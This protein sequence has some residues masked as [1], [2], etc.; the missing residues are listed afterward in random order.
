MPSPER[1]L[2]NGAAAR[3]P[4]GRPRRL[5]SVLPA[6]AHRSKG[7]GFKDW[8]LLA[9][10]LAFTAVSALMWSGDPDRALVAGAFFGLC[11]VVAATTVVR[12]LRNARLRPLRAAIAGG[13]SIRPSRGRVL[14]LAT[15][16]GGLGVVIAVFGSG[17]PW[18]MRA[19]GWSLVLVGAGLLAGVAF[20]RIP[21]EYLRFDPQG[22][23]FGGR[24]FSTLVPWDRIARVAQ[25]ELHDNAV[26]LLW[27]DDP[28]AVIA[29]PASH[30]QRAVGKL[31]SNEAWIGAH[32][33]VMTGLYG[34]D[35]PLLAAAVEGY[36][37]DP[38]SRVTLG[39]HFVP[40][41]ADVAP[42]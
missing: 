41:P 4:E 9:I 34:F 31:L 33:M 23:T 38:A 5:R 17:F 42:P 6:R 10:S 32:L 25:G 8:L 20:G 14:A 18:L 7:P 11:T 22:I 15:A 36:C 16:V 21:A 2:S 29:T 19:M 37:R 27:V 30:Q 3:Y 12:K 28:A 39:Q 40:A 24:R 26:L 35:L 13:V 1:A